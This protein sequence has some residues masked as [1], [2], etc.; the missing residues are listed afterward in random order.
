MM[1]R[2]EKMLPMNLKTKKA[3]EL[4]QLA[5]MMRKVKKKS[6]RIMVLQRASLN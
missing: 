3:M 2:R 5:R 4:R 6:R 1:A